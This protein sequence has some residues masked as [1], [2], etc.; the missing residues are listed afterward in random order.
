MLEDPEFVLDELG[1][2][3]AALP[4]AA[5]SGYR[6]VDASSWGTEPPEG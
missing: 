1:D 4:P 6:T 5:S 3:L 2:W